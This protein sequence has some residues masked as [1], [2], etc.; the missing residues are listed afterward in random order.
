MI[1]QIQEKQT[2]NYVSDMLAMKTAPY[3]INIGHRFSEKH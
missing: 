3:L 1:H 2:N